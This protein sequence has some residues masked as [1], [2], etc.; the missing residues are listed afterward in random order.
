MSHRCQPKERWLLRFDAGICESE[1]IIVRAIFDKD[2][3]RS[4]PLILKENMR[5]VGC[6]MARPGEIGLS[7]IHEDSRN[8][9]EILK[10][11]QT[12]N[13]SRS[14]KCLTKLKVQG[15]YELRE[16]FP[17]SPVFHLD[18]LR[19]DKPF[20]GHSQIQPMPQE[21]DLERAQEL[22]VYLLKKFR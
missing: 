19:D 10:I 1:E 20:E 6:F 13:P 12:I 11:A 22:G 17:E 4:N 3:V 5:A 8:P 14:L 21:Q 7:V 16:E 9:Q 18:I 15:I 2:V